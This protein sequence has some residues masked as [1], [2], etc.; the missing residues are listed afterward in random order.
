[1]K[2]SQHFSRVNVAACRRLRPDI[3]FESQ[4]G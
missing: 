2:P 4:I 3:K 1:M